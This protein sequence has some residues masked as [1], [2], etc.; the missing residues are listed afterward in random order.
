MHRARVA[1]FLAVCV[2]ACVPIR[3]DDKDSVADEMLLNAVV[4]GKDADVREELAH[5]ANPDTRDAGGR[6]VVFLA[7]LSHH[8]DSVHALLDAGATA[9]N[10]PHDAGKV[11]VTPLSIV[12]WEGKLEFVQ[13]LMEKH[14]DFKLNDFDAWRGAVVS[15]SA[16]I[17][18]MLLTAD[19]NVNYRF[20][21]GQSPVT[22]AA[23]RGNIDVLALLLDHKGNVNFRDNTGVTPL[24]LA[25]AR[26]YETAVR[27]LLDRGAVTW[28]LS[29]NGLNAFMAASQNT[30][31]SSR[32]NIESLLLA[33]GAAKVAQNRDIDD[34][35]LAAAHAGNLEQVRKLLDKGADVEVRGRPNIKLWLRDALSA[36][37]AHPAV[38]KL[39]IER[40]ANVHMVD[41]GG[42]TTLHAAA[43]EGSAECIKALGA[44]GLDPNL[45][46]HTRMTA[47]DFAIERGRPPAIVAA[48]HA[49][50]AGAKTPEVAHQRD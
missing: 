47:L 19:A 5:G 29:T 9:F 31:A 32:A 48:L 1:A 16:P 33:H 25:A 21:D 37:V 41:G 34:D 3:A 28:P 12:T 20:A 44:A 43:R 4:R 49:I 36:S 22:I 26:G 45:E 39:L 13:P 17:V 50:G 23:V 27:M 14:A 11:T 18:Q 46:S 38:C 6:P 40:G 35:L 8:L 7:V 15:G 2:I 30:N 10:E 42:F 24:M